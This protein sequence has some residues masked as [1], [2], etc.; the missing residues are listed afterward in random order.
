[1]NMQMISKLNAIIPTKREKVNFTAKFASNPIKDTFEKS[2]PAQDDVKSTMWE[3]KN[4]KYKDGNKFNDKQLNKLNNILETAPEKAK[5]VLELAKKPN[6]NGEFTYLIAMQPADK[7]ESINVFA[8][9]KNDKNEFKFSG[10]DL[11]H[12]SDKTMTEDLVRISP[13]AKTSMSAKNLVE[14]AQIKNLENIDKIANEILKFEKENPQKKE[15]S[16]AMN[17]YNKE[18]IV[19]KITNEDNSSK[20]KHFDKNLK[21]YAIETEHSEKSQ[22]GFEYKIKKSKDL[23]NNSES[24]IKLR[25]DEKVGRPVAVK[26]IQTKKDAKGNVI[27]KTIAEISDLKGVLNIKQVD[28]DGNV[29]ELSSGVEDKETGKIT[30]KKNLTSLD[31][32]NTRYVF[33]QEKNG[34]FKSQYLIVDK[35]G[36]ELLNR[37]QSL[38]KVGENKL[39]STTNNDKYEITFSDKEIKVQGIT[40]PEKTAVFNSDKDMDGDKKMLMNLLKQVPASELI[41]VREEI[42]FFASVEDPL[43]SVFMGPIKAIEIGDSPATLLHEIGHAMDYK[44]VDAL[45]YEATLPNAIAQDKNVKLAY[46]EEKELFTKNFTDVDR[47]HID[48]FINEL[49]HENG[50]QGVLSEV[51]AESNEMLNTAL[52]IE[53]FVF[54]SQVLQQYF[55]RTISE[56]SKKIEKI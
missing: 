50:E 29:K 31:G 19:V 43:D 3:L 56:I 14:V 12:L 6:I 15:T 8:N 49:D 2:K 11:I 34:E 33:E 10:K 26:E 13:L 47:N 5:P 46:S 7:I 18:D 17:K 24:E 30:I 54:R 27:Q 55:P 16:L 28:K 35:S 39:I 23:R 48:Y 21:N 20:T 45:N 36:K 37:K 40:N 42:E 52:T 22:D 38:E 25:V 51:V 41:K 1:M 53:P 9:V 44:K 32:T 4:T